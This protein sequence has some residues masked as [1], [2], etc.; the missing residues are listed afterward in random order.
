[1]KPDDVSLD[2]LLRLQGD[3]DGGVGLICRRCDRGGA[4][5]AY[6]TAHGELSPYADG[7]VKLVTRMAALLQAACAHLLE[8]HGQNIAVTCDSA[9]SYTA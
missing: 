3:E 1:M 7:P 5:I 8:D 2:D 6:Y 9:G 4:P